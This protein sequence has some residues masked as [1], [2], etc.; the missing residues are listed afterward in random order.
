[1]LFEV[2]PSLV[3]ALTS[4]QLVVL[5]KRLLLA[6]CR[7]VGLPLRAA[8]V[9]LQITIA[10][11][12]EDGRVDWEGGPDATDYFPSR[13]SIFQAKAQ[14]LT[15]SSITE[16]VIK[17]SGTK[18]QKLNAAVADAI[19][20][21]GA[22][23]IFCSHAFTGQKKDRLRTA[24]IAAI[25]KCK[26]S[27]PRSFR[28]DIYD[29]NRI[30]DWVNS[31]PPVA[32]W[33][34]EISRAR[35]YAGF[36]SQDAWA[37]APEV[38]QVNWIKT[39]DP[40]FS[41]EGIV[42][43]DAARM[44]KDRNAWTFRQAA[45][46]LQA[47]LSRDGTSA[48]IA[49]PSGFGKTRFVFEVFNERNAVADATDSSILFYANFRVVGTELAKL[50]MEIAD[51]GSPAILIADECPDDVHGDL[52]S[53]AQRQG[54]RLRVVTID[55]D[56]LVAPSDET[57]VLRLEAASNET[58]SAIAQTVD[59]SID[60]ATRRFVEQVSV[61]FPRMAVLAAPAGRQGRAVVR[62]V[63]ELVNRIVWG[64]S[65]PD[66]QSRVALEI[67]SM[68]EWIGIDGDAVAEAD[69]AASLG[70]M[71]RDMFI[72]HVRSFEHRGIV[73]LR[74]DFAQI[75]PLP[76]AAT[77]AS[78]RLGSLSQQRLDEFWMAAPERVKKALLRR[79]RWLDS[80]AAAQEF[81]RRLL[82]ATVLGN[83]AQ[84]STDFGADCV[85]RLSHVVPKD[86]LNTIESVIQGLDA[87]GIKALGSGRRHLVWALERLAF[88]CDGFMRA[89]TLLRKL[90]CVETEPSIANNAT[91]QYQQ[92]F[93]LY[94]GGNEATPAERLLVLDEGLNSKDSREIEVSVGALERMLSMFHYSR[95][96]SAE[97]IGTQ[98][99]RE[100][101]SP[102][103][104]LEIQSYYLEAVTRLTAIAVGGSPLAQRAKSILGS[105]I[106]GLL[107]NIP[108]TD[109]KTM[110]AKVA[111]GSLWVQAV[112]G[113]NSWLFFDRNG[114]P[115]DQTVAVRELYSELLPQ[116]AVER[117]ILFAQ[118]W[119]T[120]LHDP[121][122]PYK[123]PSNQ[124][125]PREVA[126]VFEYVEVTLSQL[127][128][129]IAA[130]PDQ[131]SRTL[132]AF[133]GTPTHSAFTFASRLAQVHR[134]PVKLFNKALA[135]VEA[136]D[137]AP[138]MQFF[139]GLISG[140]ESLD[141]SGGRKCVG[142]ALR[143]RSL[144]DNAIN[145]IGAGRLNGQDLKQ[146]AS[147]VA[148]HDV[149]PWTC[150]RLSY[151]RSMD[152]LSPKDIRP[153][154]DA[155]FD[156]GSSGLWTGIEIIFMYWH[157]G[158]PVD[159]ILGKMA[160]KGLLSKKLLAANRG[161]LDGHHFES[162]VKSLAKAGLLHAKEV[163]GLM[164]QIIRL[165][166]PKFTDAHQELG[167]AARN[168]LPTLISIDA[169]EVWEELT[170]HARNEEWLAAYR[171]E[172]LIGPPRRAPMEPGPLFEIPASKYLKWARNQPNKR[173]SWIAHWLPLATKTDSGASEW[174]PAMLDFLLEFHAAN[175]VLDQVAIRLY[176]RT[177]WGS[178]GPHLKPSLLLLEQLK[179]QPN[180]PLRRFAE[181]KIAAMNATAV[182]ESKRDARVVVLNS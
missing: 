154:I 22:Y 133:S 137:A 43:A 16:E 107:S 178:I 76:I 173:A 152:H 82:S 41:P 143:S 29:A 158:K 69:L 108:L 156:R 11:G 57:A 75:A 144:K 67:A 34:N 45:D 95:T 166:L 150:A 70:G 106:R 102:R 122:V 160:L 80:S 161:L 54:S 2:Q 163:H 25:R 93:Q 151:G 13:L 139:A 98:A 88:S 96:G 141:P 176:P 86:A 130:V 114:A 8:E 91:G 12:G 64:R 33:L 40:R 164:T 71:S 46:H 18:A 65:T 112:Q 172:S 113:V 170:R 182:Q 125:D 47:F 14:N 84:L 99:P 103:T 3:A 174:H 52:A 171:L 20:K 56:T 135:I 179:S 94:L 105:S 117:A 55:V 60:E 140:I 77:L 48:R 21:N 35:S 136:G 101:W 79:M 58:I 53:Y 68:F 162:M 63:K 44:S 153:L 87:A 9:P 159:A 27:V 142:K 31:H 38:H 148:S 169:K 165:F 10:D 28:C 73:I 157:G 30:T 181:V 6:E 97:E 26:V 51:A 120:D 24:I 42:I 175:G 115:A 81:S 155:L 85:E 4:E 62:S 131:V 17:K 32:L 147:L 100:D 124:D 121:D 167:G 118:S 146:V 134:S 7:K 123:E 119:S 180:L 168:I 23:V 129:A 19:R 90:A 89:A 1:M 78:D 61:G 50:A 59:P 109:V 74:G 15:D 72:D 104:G 149:E 37:K 128:E 111:A 116:D 39:D 127:A 145:L 138:N 110:I 132:L 177:W 5:M 92:L 126:R 83:Q 36:Q 49:G 66:R